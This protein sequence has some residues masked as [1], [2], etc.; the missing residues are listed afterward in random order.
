MAFTLFHADQM[1]LV[2]IKEVTTKSLGHG[3]IEVAVIVESTKLTPTHSAMDRK[4]RTT[5]LDL[6]SLKAEKAQVV[7]GQYGSD[8]LFRSSTIQLGIPL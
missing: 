5:R 1:G 7:F 6:V 2:R 3:L 4:Q 8:F